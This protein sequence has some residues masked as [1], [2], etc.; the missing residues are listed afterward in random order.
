MYKTCSRPREMH[1]DG[2]L[3]S[4]ELPRLQLVENLG[5]SC[6]VNE[7]S[8]N[9]LLRNPNLLSSSHFSSIVQHQILHLL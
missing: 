5:P 9:R 8:L 6:L 1:C 4:M 7:L 2:G 3:S